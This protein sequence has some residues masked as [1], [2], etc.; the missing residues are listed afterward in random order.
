MRIEAEARMMG[1]VVIFY[2]KTRFTANMWRGPRGF[3]HAGP[4]HLAASSAQC[5]RAVQTCPG[6]LILIALHG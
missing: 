5:H 2:V 3:R 6:G 1:C 4:Q